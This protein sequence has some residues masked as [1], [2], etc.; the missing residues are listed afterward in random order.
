MDAHCKSS[1]EV[2]T[3]VLHGFTF[4]DPPSTHL[5]TSG[6]DDSTTPTK[7]SFILAVRARVPLLLLYKY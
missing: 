3:Q 5:F 6:H 4:Y 7:S 1:F 2:T